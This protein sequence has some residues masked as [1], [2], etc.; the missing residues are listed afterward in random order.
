MRTA[1]RDPYLMMNSFIQFVHE[2]RKHCTNLL[3]LQDLSQ[4]VNVGA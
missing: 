2:T 4:S 3:T 1:E